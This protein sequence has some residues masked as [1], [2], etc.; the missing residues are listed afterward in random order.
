MLHTHLKSKAECRVY[1]AFCGLDSDP[2]INHSSTPRTCIKIITMHGHISHES[3]LSETAVNICEYHDASDKDSR[4]PCVQPI[5]DEP[6]VSSSDDPTSDH[7]RTLRDSDIEGKMH[8]TVRTSTWSQ[9]NSRISWKRVVNI[10][11][12]SAKYS[13][14]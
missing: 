7:H 14:V 9:R 6:I 11:L 5:L 12:C 3:C 8:R 13:Q 2:I 10:G 4:L 1:I